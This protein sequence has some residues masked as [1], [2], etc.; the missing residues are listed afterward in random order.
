MYQLEPNKQKNQ[1]KSNL[2]LT[3]EL[4]VLFWLILT[5]MLMTT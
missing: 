2:R 1:I 5:I 4:Y 3:L